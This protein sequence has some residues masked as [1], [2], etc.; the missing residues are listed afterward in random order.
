M[1]LYPQLIRNP[2]YKANKK[3]GGVIPIPIDPRV[4]YVPI[5]CSECIECRNQKAR[6]WQIRLL[7]EVKTNTNGKFITLTFSNENYAKLRT[8][9]DD[10]KALQILPQLKGYTL[11]NQIAT[12]ALR[13]FLERWR[14]K[15]KTS[16]RHFTITELGHENTENIHLHGILWTN[17]SFKTI[18]KIW[19]YGYIWPSQDERKHNYVNAETVN[20]IIKYITKKDLLHKNYK[21]IIL[22]SP[23]IG[24]QY[25]YHDHKFNNT[26][27]IEYYRTSTGHKMAL[28]I[29]YRNKIFTDTERELLWLNRL[30]KNERWVCGEKIAADNTKQYFDTLRWHRTRNKKLGYG[31]PKQYWNHNQYQQLCDELKVRQEKQEQR[32]EKWLL[33]LDVPF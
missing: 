8:N 27:T 7:E 19:N 10:L 32:L 2:K 16:L 12:K 1:C 5:G 15:F 26:E 9:A 6:S 31:K 17:E 18:E 22:A 20:Y 13:L 11:D 14:K 3:N 28:P 4:L 24:S 29:Y 23:G 30:D 25:R 33:S 21:S